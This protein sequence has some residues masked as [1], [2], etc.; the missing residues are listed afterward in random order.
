MASKEEENQT[1]SKRKWREIS[2]WQTEQMRCA[3]FGPCH[4]SDS[5]NTVTWQGTTLPIA[6]HLFLTL[7]HDEG[8][9]G[10]R[11]MS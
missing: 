10:V 4:I 5:Q 9:F 3:V 2:I 11:T 1:D 7:M 6:L 8:D